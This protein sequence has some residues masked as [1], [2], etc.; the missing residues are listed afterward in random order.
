MCQ[1][2]AACLLFK[3]SIFIILS[4]NSESIFFSTCQPIFAILFSHVKNLIAQRNL[5]SSITFHSCKIQPKLLSDSRH[6]AFCLA[7][8]LSV[9][10]A[11]LFYIFSFLHKLFKKYLFLVNFFCKIS[12]K[13]TFQS[14][15]FFKELF[16]CFL[17][18]SSQRNEQ[19]E[20]L[21]LALI[22][23]VNCRSMCSFDDFS[24]FNVSI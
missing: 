18:E 10:A 20:F 7:S 5:F 12:T 16:T 2:Q 3:N 19:E 1:V 22:C 21:S 13:V 6:C 11:D 9:L 24:A 15:N 23:S 17:H 14:K 8:N 4:Y